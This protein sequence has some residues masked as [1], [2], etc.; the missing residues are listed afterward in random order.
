MIYIHNKTERPETIY[1]KGYIISSGSYHY[2]NVK[3]IYDQKLE[4]PYNDCFKNVSKSIYYNQTIVEYFKEKNIEYTQNECLH[5]C[6][7]FMFK[8]TNPCN[9]RIE[10]DIFF[11][12]DNNTCI[13]LF[14]QNLSNSE[15]CLKKYCPLECDSLVYEI[16]LHSISE[17]GY[18]NIS[19]KSSPF[20]AGFNTY[21]NVSRTFYAIRVY[22]QDLKYTLISQ[23][24]KIELFGL[25]SNV[26]G[27]LGLFL[28]FS[29]ISLLELFEIVAELVFIRFY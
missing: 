6:I 20:Y 15:I 1:N 26:G 28:G 10:K 2:F 5:S 13:Q 14:I 24:P 11:L 8:E 9:K 4:S 12:V 23:Q 17:T 16:N 3:R 27:T 21:E 22:Y 25:I 18:G 29:F 7:N 19:L